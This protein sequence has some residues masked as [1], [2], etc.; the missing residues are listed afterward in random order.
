MTRYVTSDLILADT[1]TIFIQTADAVEMAARLNAILQAD[2]LVA[3]LA[4]A[5]AG[6]GHT[7]VVSVETTETATGPLGDD[8]VIGCYL[9][10]SEQ[11]LGVAKQAMVT[12]L[13]A[14]TPPSPGQVLSIIDEQIAGSAKGTVFMGMLVATWVSVG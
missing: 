7:F 1:P 14:L 4:L 5:G 3:S 10:A 13:L 12:E 11:A 2:T 6:D 8:S 9:G